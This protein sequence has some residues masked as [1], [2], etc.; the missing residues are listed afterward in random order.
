MSALWPPLARYCPHNPTERQA[1]FLLL[2]C[3]EAFYGGAAG[4]GKSDALLMAA[5]QYV[6]RPG[7]AALILRRTFKQLDLPGAIMARAKQWLTGRPGVHWNDDAKTF[8]FGGPGGGT[9][10]FGYLENESD[11]YRYQGPEFQF[12]GFDE[13]T[14]FAE[15]QYRYLFSRTRRLEGAGVPVRMRSASNPG[16]IGHAWVKRRFV[17]QRKPGVVFIPAKLDDN[18][19]LDRAEYIHSLS[20]LDETLQRQLLDG[21]WGAF[22]GA[23]FTIGDEHLIDEFPLADSHDRFEA[24][25]YGLNGAPWALW[26]VDYEGNLVGY[27]MLYERDLIPSQLCPLVLS[28]RA[29]GWGDK[30]PA[31]ID[32]S[33]WK[34]TG[35]RN[36]FGDPAMLS[37][38]FTDN[39]VT[40]T[41]AN[42]DPRAGLIR[43]RELLRVDPQHP[44][45][46]WHERAGQPGAPRLFFVRSRMADCVEEL[47]S[48]PLQPIEA[49]DGGEIIDPKWESQYGHTVAM[50]RYAVMTRPS[51]SEEPQDWRNELLEPVAA[52]ETLREEALRR[53]EEQVERPSRR[54]PY[55][56]V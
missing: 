52:P 41:R 11:V 9:L 25:D 5:L 29:A 6:D 4:G 24:A 20:E 33:V 42:N 32:P 13:L 45:P 49:R 40:I 7:Y 47:R 43:L 37:D 35:T 23:A 10:T 27:D 50:T 1:A 34:R 53:H 3:Q 30:H 54:R 14:Q 19:H 28:R 39:G 56:R 8:T 38:E 36:R 26:C 22:E 55:T 16:G 31:Y 48:A 12:V 15:S 18:P 21:D 2:D 17:E 46:N 44:F 51:P